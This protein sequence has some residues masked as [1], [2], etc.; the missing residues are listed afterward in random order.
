MNGRRTSGVCSLIRQR[1]DSI[2]EEEKKKKTVDNNV[3][4]VCKL[5]FVG[6]TIRYPNHRVGS[7]VGKKKYLT[8][9][10]RQVPRTASVRGKLFCAS[11]WN[12]SHLKTHISNHVADQTFKLHQNIFC[13]VLTDVA[14]YSRALIFPPGCVN[15]PL[16]C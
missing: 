9:R 6:R 3:I 11:F 5:T 16:M 7:T 14:S 13:G 10:G 4:T 8:L 1:R 12:K 2:S 15:T